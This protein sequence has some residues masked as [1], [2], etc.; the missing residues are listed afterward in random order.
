[1]VRLVGEATAQSLDACSP[2]C[3]ELKGH[4]EHVGRLRPQGQA[5]S[6]DFSGPNWLDQRQAA[7]RYA[8]RDPAV[9]VVGGGQ[10]GLSIAARLD[11]AAISTRWSSTAG[12]ASATTG[13]SATTRSRCTTRCTSITCPTCRSRRTGRCTSRRTSSPTG[14]S[15]TPRAMEL[16]YW[17]GTEFAGG[18][19]DEQ[20]TDAGRCACSARWQRARAASAPR[21]HGHRRQRHPEHPGHSRRCATFS[22]QGDPFAAST[23]DGAP[24]SGKR[25]LVI[26]TGTSGHDIA[27]DLL[28]ERRARDHRPAQP[29]A[30]HQLRAERAARLRPLQRRPAARGLRPD[31]RFGAARA[32]RKRTHQLATAHAKELDQRR[33][34]AR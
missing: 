10:A 22:G 2:R 33:P 13:A 34:R 8:D 16:N 4:E 24:W 23:R 3:D 7:A 9:L 28:L 20:A 15:P 26:G 31:H 1:M 12:R 29:D 19:Y 5:Y 6:R 27:Q 17:T 25:A 32:F 14:S 21:R 18:S 11:A 30:H